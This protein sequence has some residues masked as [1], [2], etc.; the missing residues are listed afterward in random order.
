MQQDRF[1]RLGASMYIPATRTDL[2]AHANGDKNPWLRSMIFCT[3]DAVRQEDLPTALRNIEQA[4]PQ[5]RSRESAMR[6][7]RVRDPHVMGRLLEMRGIENVCG[8]VLPKVTARNISHY[9][10]L[11]TSRSKFQIMPTLETRE[12]FDPVE[13]RELRDMLEQQ[14]V[15]SRVLTLRIGGNDALHTLGVRRSATKTI[16]HTALGATIAMLSG[17]FKPFGFNLSGPVFEGMTQPKVLR[18]EVERDLQNGLFGKTAI[19]PDQVAI[20]EEG[21]KVTTT[22]LDSAQC[23]LQTDAP[24]VFRLHDCMCEGATQWRWAQ[25]IIARSEMYGVREEHAEAS[26]RRPRVLRMT[27]PEKEHL[28]AASG[29]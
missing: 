2:V 6:F 8:F 26:R 15:R 20:I 16:Y 12:I 28:A 9:T 27:P 29:S 10:T 24:A 18:R 5:M 7:I 22:D 21:Y 3:E 25:G 23:I 19:H 1:L 17:L 11:L 13:M 4:L 14:D